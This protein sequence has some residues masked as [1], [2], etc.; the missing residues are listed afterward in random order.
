MR[1]S[2][3]PRTV[4]PLIIWNAWASVVDSDRSHSHV[5][6]RSGLP[7]VFKNATPP[8]RAREAEPP[9]AIGACRNRSGTPT[10]WLIASS[11]HLGGQQPNDG[12]REIRIVAGVRLVRRRAQLVGSRLHDPSDQWLQPHAVGLEVGGDRVQE[13]GVGRRIRLAEIIDRI[14]DAPA[15]QVKPDPVGQVPAELRVVARQPVR[16]PSRA[17]SSSPAGSIA[18]G[19]LR[20][21]GCKTCSGAGL[22]HLGRPDR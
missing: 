1:V 21:F 3:L 18:T 8:G 6:S 19:P 9:A 20:H 14:D 11:K 15:Q 16:Q 7:K 17:L 4:S 13:R 12:M 10:T 5:S 2:S 22:D